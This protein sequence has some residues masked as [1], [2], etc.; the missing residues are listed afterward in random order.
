MSIAGPVHSPCV[1]YPLLFKER[2]I[3]GGQSN[4]YGKHRFVA[5]LQHREN[6]DSRCFGDR[7]CR[8]ALC[9][10][11]RPA[12]SWRAERFQENAG[13]LELHPYWRE[14]LSAVP[15]TDDCDLDRSPGSSVVPE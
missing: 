12:D 1:R 9:G 13:S 7:Y 15:V 4:I 14:C 10:L 5:N 3:L 6:D 11:S 8:A 2:L